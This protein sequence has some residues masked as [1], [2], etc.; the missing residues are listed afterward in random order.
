[1]RACLE[2]RSWSSGI[3]LKEQKPLGQE[4]P[5]GSGRMPP[6][7]MC[8]EATKAAGDI[9]RSQLV[10]GSTMDPPHRGPH[11]NKIPGPR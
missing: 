8:L 4:A 1:M 2:E 5:T 3:G 9:R 6:R 11:V 10:L 7:V